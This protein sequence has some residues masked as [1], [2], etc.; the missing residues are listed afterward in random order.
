MVGLPAAAFWAGPRPG[1][2]TVTVAEAAG[3]TVGEYSAPVPARSAEVPFATG[4]SNV[5]E[6]CVPLQPVQMPFEA[7]D[8]RQ[9]HRGPCVPESRRE[10]RQP[11]S[12]PRRRLDRSG[13]ADA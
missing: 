8:R 10:A 11:A 5:G 6:A 13:A 3:V 7:R 2:S 4:K 12:R 1:M 9:V